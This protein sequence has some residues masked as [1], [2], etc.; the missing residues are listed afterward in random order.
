MAFPP[1][2]RLNI[3]CGLGE[4]ELGLG[5]SNRARQRLQAALAL[6]EPGTE[7]RTRARI[8]FAL[9]R[10]LPLEEQERAHALAE[11]ALQEL[12]G[13]SPWSRHQRQRIEAWLAAREAN[14]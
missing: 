1:G 4:A 5:R 9:A 13:R 10:A 11:T 12:P 7:P 3:L 8:R 14:R 2:G 6:I